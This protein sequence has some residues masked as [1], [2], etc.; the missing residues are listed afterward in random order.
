MLHPPLVPEVRRNP[1]MARP[2]RGAQRAESYLGDAREHLTPGVRLADRPIRLDGDQNLVDRRD[3]GFVE[4]TTARQQ[5]AMAIHDTASVVGADTPTFSRRMKWWTSG[6]R[7]V[8][9]ILR[10]EP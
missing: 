10:R 3:V 5:R 1:V 8:F 7:E 2:G 6:T 9:R 4:G